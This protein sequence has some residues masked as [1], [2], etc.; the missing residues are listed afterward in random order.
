LF[1]AYTGFQGDDH[2]QESSS[3][4]ILNLLVNQ[5]ENQ[6]KTKPAFLLH[7]MTAKKRQP[8]ILTI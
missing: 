7:I 3:V 4:I 1:I 2:K 6:P 5:Q 8:A